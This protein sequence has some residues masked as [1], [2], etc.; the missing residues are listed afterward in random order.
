MANCMSHLALFQVNKNCANILWE[1]LDW[2]LFLQFCGLVFSYL[3]Q[4]VCVEACVASLYIFQKLGNHF[5]GKLSW[6]FLTT[7]GV[8]SI[9]LSQGSHDSFP[10]WFSYFYIYSQSTII[11]SLLHPVL[12]DTS[13]GHFHDIQ[14]LIVYCLPSISWFMG[15]MGS[16]PTSTILI[17]PKGVCIILLL[18]LGICSIPF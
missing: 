3:E 7:Q 16:P 18:S 1:A 4:V 17:I 12:C 10:L 13:S 5:L 9:C 8:S 14:W 6:M 15:R 2:S 11:A